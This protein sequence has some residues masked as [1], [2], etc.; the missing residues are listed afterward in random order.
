MDRAKQIVYRRTFVIKLI[1]AHLVF[2]DASFEAV[3]EY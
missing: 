3:N 1:D 2:Y